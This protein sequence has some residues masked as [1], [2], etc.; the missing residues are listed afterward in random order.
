MFNFLKSTKPTRTLDQI[1]LSLSHC[2]VSM[3][4][5]SLQ[6]ITAL[7]TYR[8]LVKE[9]AKIAP[10]AEYTNTG[11]KWRINVTKGGKIEILPRGRVVVKYYD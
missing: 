7:D 4:T 9:R 8:E 3:G 5:L 11:I 2:T 6:Q 10:K 1:D